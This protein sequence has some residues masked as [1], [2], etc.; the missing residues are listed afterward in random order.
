MSKEKLTKEELKRAIDKKD[1]IARKVQELET[2]AAALKK[3]LQAMRAE[4]TNSK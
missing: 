4:R 2:K 1:Y 3:E